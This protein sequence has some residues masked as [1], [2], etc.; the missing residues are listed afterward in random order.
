M[1]S[2]AWAM[3]LFGVQKMVDALGPAETNLSG[4][5][6]N[7][8]LPSPLSMLGMLGPFSPAYWLSLGSEHL[9]R[10]A[11]HSTPARHPQLA[12]VLDSEPS[13]L[14]DLPPEPPALSPAATAVRARGSGWGPM[15]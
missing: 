9:L 6:K 13:S 11:P 5:A 12:S 8:G 10:P 4:Q 3:S 15:P 2:Y 1:F 7:A 14:L